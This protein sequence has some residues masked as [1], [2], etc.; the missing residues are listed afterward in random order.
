MKKIFLS[1]LFSVFYVFAIATNIHTENVRV[2]T[3][4]SVVKWKGSKVTSFHEGNV[5]ITKGYLTINHG[6]LVGGEFVINM[7]SITCTDIKSKKKNDYFVSHIKN[8]DFFDVEKFPNT[9]IKIVKVKMERAEEKNRYKI[10]ADLT[11]KGI[12]HPISF[13][14]DVDINGSNFL[15]K[16]KIKIDRT[17]WGI[18]Y[19]SGSFF[20]D[21]GDKLILDE[22][23]FDIFLLSVKQ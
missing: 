10:L 22:I 17:K 2:N 19:N 21:L 4:N 13:F 1:L 11:I 23:E 18:E 9:I 20:K 12:T 3:E 5:S 8:E 16:A 6:T 14:A 15:A 7:N